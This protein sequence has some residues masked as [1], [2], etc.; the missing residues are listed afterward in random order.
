M[1]NASHK[2]GYLPIILDM[3]RKSQLS[4]LHDITR[5]NDQYSLVYCVTDVWWLAS[6]LF[7]KKDK[8]NLK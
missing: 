1:F 5:V 6:K 8:I 3:N 7:Y 4:F 2:Q